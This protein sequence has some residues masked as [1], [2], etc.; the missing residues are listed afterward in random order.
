MPSKNENYFENTCLYRKKKGSSIR[1]GMRDMTVC[2][3][4]TCTS[5]P[6]RSKVKI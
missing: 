5:D 1:F 4:S 3:I 2:W 6:W